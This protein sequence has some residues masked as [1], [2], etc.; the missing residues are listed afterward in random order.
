M[1][2][3]ITKRALHLILCLLLVSKQGICP[4][5]PG[6]LR[7]ELSRSVSILKGNG[8]KN[9][10][11]SKNRIKKVLTTEISEFSKC[12]NDFD[13]ALQNYPNSITGETLEQEQLKILDYA[14]KFLN[15][16]QEECRDVFKENREKFV[17]SR[18]QNQ[19]T[20]FIPCLNL[21]DLIYFNLTKIK[22]LSLFNYVDPSQFTGPEKTR[23]F[24][25][26][27]SYNFYERDGCHKLMIRIQ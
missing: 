26:K 4:A 16:R 9:K 15:G 5:A 7:K 11:A 18:D 19:N 22:E 1:R 12:L 21:V 17:A 23:F 27:E 8:F 10:E 25:Y 6:F 20:E 2:I 3:E 24:Q 14:K 13:A